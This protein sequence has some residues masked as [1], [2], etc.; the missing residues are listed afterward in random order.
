MHWK[1]INFEYISL[2]L[3][4]FTLCSAG[5]NALHIVFINSSYEI[6]AK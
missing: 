3:C 4:L 1:N 5:V 2:I 6:T